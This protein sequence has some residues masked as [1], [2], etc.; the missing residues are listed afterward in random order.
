MTKTVPLVLLVAA[1]IATASVA[2]VTTAGIWWLA[3]P[4]S[5]FLTVSQAAD[6]TVTTPGDADPEPDEEEVEPDYW[7]IGFGS[8]GPIDVSM[9]AIEA[10]DAVGTQ[11]PTDWD[12][13]YCWWFIFDDSAD[14]GMLSGPASVTGGSAGPLDFIYM[15]PTYANGAPLPYDETRTPRTR[16]GI[17]F[18]ST[19]SDLEAAYP[20]ELDIQ[21]NFYDPAAKDV[22]VYG[23]NKM[24]IRF[25]VNSAGEVGSIATGRDEPLHWW[26]VCG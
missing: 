25:D 14:T 16:E 19:L 4:S 7:I 8:V 26:E 13:E 2:A 24:T 15:S 10:I 21:D 12:D 5:S 1:S 22:Y 23:P 18:G 11:P 6:P 3:S 9:T 17:T 20:G